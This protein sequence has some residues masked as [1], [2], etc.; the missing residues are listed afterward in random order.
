MIIDILDFAEIMLVGKKS[1]GNISEII[2]SFISVIEE[3]TEMKHRKAF[4][5]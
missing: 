2:E 3:K 5:I 1:G 4:Q